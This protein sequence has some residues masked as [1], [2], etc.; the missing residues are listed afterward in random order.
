MAIKFAS[1]LDLVRTSR[2]ASPGDPAEIIP[3]VYGDFSAGGLAGPIPAKLINKA[4]FV[5]AAA[6]HEVGSITNV[7]DGEVEKTIGVDV[8]VNI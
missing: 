2:Y 1:P 4:G 3:D 7:Y 5:Y 8:A 6:A